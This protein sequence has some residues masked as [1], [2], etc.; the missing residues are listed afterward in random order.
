MKVF[1]EYFEFTQFEMAR[2]N[3]HTIKRPYIWFHTGMDFQF[4]EYHAN[5]KLQCLNFHRLIN[6]CVNTYGYFDFLQNLKCLEV[7][8]YFKQC[9]QLNSFFAYHKKYYPNEY[10]QSEYWRVSPHYDSVHLDQ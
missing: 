10:Y 1:P 9:L 8:E 3:M 2:E 7:S 5:L 6:A 4:Q